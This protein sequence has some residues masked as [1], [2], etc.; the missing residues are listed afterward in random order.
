MVRH[1][2]RIAWGALL[3]AAALFGCGRH[4]ADV[5]R[6]EGEDE[7][8]ALV[9]PNAESHTNSDPWLAEHHD[10]IGRMQP[11]VLVLQFLNLESPAVWRDHVEDV[12]TTLEESSRFHAYAGGAARPFL[13]YE[14]YDL[15]ALTDDS[16]YITSDL[17]PLTFDNQV[18]WTALFSPDF[19]PTLGMTDADDP[20]RLLDLCD[21]FERGTIHELWVLASP[22][23]PPEESFGA[24]R[25]GYDG[26]GSAIPGYFVVTPGFEYIP[27]FVSVRA[28]LIDV[29][30]D[31]GCAL[32]GRDAMFEETLEALPYLEANATPFLNFDLA[33]R[34]GTS[35]ESWP[36]LCG[37]TSEP[38]IDYPTPTSVEGVLEGAPPWDIDP[39]FPN[40]GSTSFAPNSRFAFDFD[41][42]AP[43]RARCRHFGMELGDELVTAKTFAGGATSGRC[44]GGWQLYKDQSMPGPRSQATDVFG[45]PMK[46]FWPFMFY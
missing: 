25:Q 10:E 32:L 36:E 16:P 11:R 9:W 29:E 15:V 18:D 35:F 4:E 17:L 30:A 6:F 28:G 46:N 34:Y 12:M 43:V 14:L 38:C 20:S 41:N 26:E 24:N 5:I 27:C 31:A 33:E 7:G 21:L 44:G 19:A 42:P 8:P 3:V 37:G 39:Y 13:D 1:R 40:C 45:D 22:F 2:P 23:G